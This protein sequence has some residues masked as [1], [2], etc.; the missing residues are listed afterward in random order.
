M[1][2]P[3]SPASVAAMR[4]IVSCDLKRLFSFSLE[5]EPLHELADAAE[6]YLVTQLERSFST[7]DFYKQLKL[8]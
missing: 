6:T 1:R 2:L 8:L 7:L 3:V 5:P 4:Y